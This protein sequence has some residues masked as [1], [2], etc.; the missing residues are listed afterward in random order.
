M[1]QS[2]QLPLVLGDGVREDNFCSVDL[3]HI[4]AMLASSKHAR[5]GRIVNQFRK[6]R[7]PLEI[8]II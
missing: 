3:A 8:K 1:I 4:Q 7:F 6:L 5:H 2:R